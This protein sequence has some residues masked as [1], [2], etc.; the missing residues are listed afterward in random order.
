MQLSN[1][2]KS[3]LH[4]GPLK[5]ET[6][7]H[8]AWKLIKRVDLSRVGGAAIWNKLTVDICSAKW[9]LMS[10][11]SDTFFSFIDCI[12]DYVLNG[13]RQLKATLEVHWRLS[14]TLLTLYNW[15]CSIGCDIGQDETENQPIRVDYVDCWCCGWKF[16]VHPEPRTQFLLNYYYFEY[17]LTTPHTAS[18][19]KAGTVNIAD[20]HIRFAWHPKLNLIT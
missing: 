16:C 15:R 11:S 5:H 8:M 3:C 4:F 19:L 9:S 18:L 12:W 20:T 7:W 1:A 10:M 17:T 13:S 6:M 14:A 2:K